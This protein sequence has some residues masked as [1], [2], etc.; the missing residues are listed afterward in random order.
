MT[1]AVKGFP[2]VSVGVDLIMLLEGSEAGVES[3]LNLSE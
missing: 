2:V 3:E 1:G